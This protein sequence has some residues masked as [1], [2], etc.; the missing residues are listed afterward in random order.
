MSD[1]IRLLQIRYCTEKNATL[2][3]LH[4]HT[5]TGLE[6]LSYIL[7][8]GKREPKVEGET[9]VPA[10]VYRLKLRDFGGFHERYEK[11]YPRMHRGMIELVD[12][13]G[14]TD[15]LIHIGNFPKNTKACLL[16]GSEPGHSAKGSLAVYS[17]RLTY[18]KFY[19][20]IADGIVSGNSFLQIVDGA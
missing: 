18:E 6:F 20:R 13:R 8:P 7:E 19:P 17:S 2:S 16:M 15:V 12:V 11:K 9:R 10:G 1:G 14:W 4:E 3:L 5:S